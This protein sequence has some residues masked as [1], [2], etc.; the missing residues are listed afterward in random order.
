MI[1]LLYEI[2][3]VR[4]DRYKI[5]RECK[6][7]MINIKLILYIYLKVIV[8]YIICDTMRSIQIEREYCIE[9]RVFVSNL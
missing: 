9:Q 4:S 6:L 5:K 7:F 1:V 8:R 2:D 3:T